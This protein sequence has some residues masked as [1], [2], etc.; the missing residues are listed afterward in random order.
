MKI[1]GFALLLT[2]SSLLVACSG[3]DAPLDMGGGDA[4]MTD[5]GG[6]DAAVTTCTMDTECTVAGEACNLTLGECRPTCSGHDECA[7]GEVCLNN[8]CGAAPACPDGNCP[9]DLICDV[10]MVC[11]PPVVCTDDTEC[12][13][14]DICAGG[15]CIAPANCAD[16]TECP[17][18]LRCIQGICDDPCTDD[19]E[20]GDPT[21]VTCETATGECRDRCLAGDD[22][23]ASGFI[24]EQFVCLPAECILD[25]DCPGADMACR[26]AADGHGRCVEAL[27]CDAQNPCP[28]NFVCNAQMQCEELPGCLVDRDCGATEVCED[29]HCQPSTACTDAT[30]CAAGEDCIGNVCVPGVCRGHIDCAAPTPFCIAGVCTAAAD[31]SV[32]TEVRIISTAAT[33][34]QY[35]EYEFEAVALDAAGNVLSGIDFD[36]V[37]MDPSIASIDTDGLSLAN[38]DGSTTV[39]ASV[40]TGAM[41][42]SSAGVSIHV[43]DAAFSG[44]RFTVV[45]EDTGEPIAGAQVLCDATQ[46]TTDARGQFLIGIVAVDTCTVF[47]PGYDY[48]TVAGIT[49]SDVE[50]RVPP[51]SIATNATGY[52]GVSDTSMVPG[53][54]PVQL[55]FSGGSIGG[56][57]FTFELDSVFGGE[58]F[59]IDVPIIGEI[60]LPSGTTAAAEF[61]GIPLNLKSDYYAVGKAG[62][63]RPWSFGGFVELGDLDLTGGNLLA[64]VLPLFQT[65]AHDTGG[66]LDTLVDVPRIVDTADFDGDGDMT[67]LVPDYAAFVPRSL[68][69]QKAMD[70]R[71]RINARAAAMPSGTT[72]LMAVAGILQPSVGF[73]PLGIDG[74]ASST[75]AGPIPFTMKLAA[76]YSGLEDGKY[77][78]LVAATE[79]MQGSLPRMISVDW[80]VFDELPGEVVVSSLVA[81][82]TGAV[83]LGNRT[84]DVMAIASPDGGA[85]RGRLLTDNGAWEVRAPRGTTQVVLPTPPQGVDDRITLTSSFDVLKFADNAQGYQLLHSLDGQSLEADRTV[86][87]FARSGP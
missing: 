45:A 39:V 48:L 74:T 24:C 56:P 6:M 23:C 76:P 38:L 78:V 67:E 18:N 62:L 73:I 2:S 20:C 16:S 33:V 55:T 29:R 10:N 44:T 71:V 22:D 34:G 8:F 64:N 36:W 30:E 59:I 32:V 50:L 25:A 28:P 27:A 41:T 47:A 17:S 70:L 58:E 65:F 80:Q 31:P 13:G 5:T 66:G 49:G 54:G 3:S 75:V 12:T 86:V 85:W 4:G 19:A 42:V 53:S 69:P 52:T 46:S 87:G 1:L 43:Y 61:Q 63:R 11:A 84:V 37:S 26:G 81:P 83:N 77:V 79:I 21:M 82:Q 35:Y 51:L 68:S 7:T 72:H 15:V 40:N 60:T 9:G 57:L 14:T